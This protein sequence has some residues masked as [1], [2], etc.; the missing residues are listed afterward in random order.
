MLIKMWL[1]LRKLDLK[2][3]FS[4]PIAISVHVLLCFDQNGQISFEIIN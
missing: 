4:S 1:K 3:S 2:T